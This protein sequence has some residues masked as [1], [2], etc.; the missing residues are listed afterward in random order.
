MA[1]KHRCP[2]RPA[3]RIARPGDAASPATTPGAPE[4]PSK[5]YRT[6]KLDG[7]VHLYVDTARLSDRDEFTNALRDLGFGNVEA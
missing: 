3:P 6:L 5:A 4:R 2:A 7:W 1:R